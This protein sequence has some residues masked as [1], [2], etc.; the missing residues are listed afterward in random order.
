MITRHRPGNARLRLWRPVKPCLCEPIVSCRQ[1]LAD[2]FS[3][4]DKLPLVEVADTSDSDELNDAEH[5]LR[6]YTYLNV[7]HDQVE[8][9]TM[10]DRVAVLDGTML[11]SWTKIR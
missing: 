2:L 6:M 5:R 11:R 1:G 3:V 4:V 7:T 8:A 9:A 10:G